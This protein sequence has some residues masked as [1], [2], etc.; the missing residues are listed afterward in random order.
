MHFTRIINL[1]ANRLFLC[2][3]VISNATIL[4]IKVEGK[5][6]WLEHLALRVDRKFCWCHIPRE[7]KQARGEI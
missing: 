2:A 6:L 7:D 5:D 3:V 1:Y 4:S